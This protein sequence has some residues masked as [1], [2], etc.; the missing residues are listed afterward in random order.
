MTNR[1]LLKE[2]NAK[3]TE[4]GLVIDKA[5]GSQ[6]DIHGMMNEY[7]GKIILDERLLQRCI[8]KMSIKGNRV[9]CSVEENIGL[10]YLLGL[11]DCVRTVVFGGDGVTTSHGH[12]KVNIYDGDITLQPWDNQ[13]LI[14]LAT[15][16]DLKI[17]PTRFERI[18]QDNELAMAKMLKENETLKGYLNEQD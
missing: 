16:Y 6:M 9:T 13:S 1:E 12:W 18:I 8:W 7:A 4:E 17:D 10:A 15:A 14:V 5:I 11:Y 2:L 3:R